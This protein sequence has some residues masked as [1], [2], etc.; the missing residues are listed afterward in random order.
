M[1]LPLKCK[2]DPGHKG[3]GLGIDTTVEA[4]SAYLR[5]KTTIVDKGEKVSGT[6]VDPKFFNVHFSA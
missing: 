1:H 6:K 2:V 4:L 5:I 3:A